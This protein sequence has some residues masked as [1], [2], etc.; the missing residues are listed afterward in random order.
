MT[1][2]RITTTALWMLIAMFVLG[3]CLKS[4]NDIAGPEDSDA[5]TLPSTSTMRFSLDFMGTLPEVDEESIRAG[6]ATGALAETAGDRSNWINAVVRAIFLQ[7]VVY[8]AL[9]EP[10]AAF[11]LAVH[12]VPQ[13]QDDGSYLW[14]YIFKDE[15]IEYSIFLYG[16]P[17]VDRVEWRMEVSTNDPAMPLDHFVWFD[18]ESLNDDSRGFWQFY[19]PVNETAPAIAA[20]TPGAEVVR[21]DWFHPGVGE[22][23]LRISVNGVG[24]PDEGDW[25]E[26]HETPG[27]GL[28]NHFDASESQDSNITA[29][30]D[31]SGSIQVPDY[32]DGVKACWDTEQRDTM[33]P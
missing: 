21:I 3:G 8:D 30:S 12:S 28:I 14:T 10:V 6:K 27:T 23:R 19:E 24:H 17:K 5:P 4:G 1:T 33:C 20:M 32:N 31:G 9:E 7:L 22:E 26:F 16:T 2:A 15:L 13:P 29:Y 18:G 25:L 11:A